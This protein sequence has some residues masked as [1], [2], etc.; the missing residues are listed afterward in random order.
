[1][2]SDTKYFG[3]GIEINLGG[4][5]ILKFPHGRVHNVNQQVIVESYLMPD[6]A[7]LKLGGPYFYILNTGIF[8]F[9]IRTNLGSAILFLNP[10]EGTCIS[11]FDNTIDK[12]WTATPPKSISH[13]P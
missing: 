8:T 11:L 3:G 6:T 2:P 12:G 13:K 10:G 4:D 9:T 5:P 7:G 1:M